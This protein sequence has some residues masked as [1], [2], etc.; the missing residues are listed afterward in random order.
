MSFPSTSTSVRNAKVE[1]QVFKH[2]HVHHRLKLKVFTRTTKRDDEQLRR[3]SLLFG[4][5]L[6]L[7]PTRPPK[8]VGILET[9]EN[10]KHFTSLLLEDESANER[11]MPLPFASKTRSGNGE[12]NDDSVAAALYWDSHHHPEILLNERMSIHNNSTDTDIDSDVDRNH[13]MNM[14]Q[15]VLNVCGDVLT[16]ASD[17]L[18]DMVDE[19]L[20]GSAIQRGCADLANAIGSLAHQLENQTEDERRDLA[21]ACLQDVSTALAVAEA[22]Q[23][24]HDLLLH[25][26][27]PDDDN[28]NVAAANATTTSMVQ[29]HREF[30]NQMQDESQ[31]VQVIAA[32]GSF[33]RD[34]E[35]TLR[36]VEQSEAQELADV[37]LTVAKIFVTSLQ[38]MH[39]QLRP[40]DL[41][42]AANSGGSGAGAAGGS[43]T[44][45]IE[46]LDDDDDDDER[47]KAATTRNQQPA[48]NNQQNGKHLQRRRQMNDRLRVLW[49]PLGPA[50]SKAL[51]WG[52]EAALAQP[53][54]LSIALAMI[55][56]P[57]AATTAI[58]GTPLVLADGFLQDMYAHFQDGPLVVGLE[59]GA[60][61]LF[62]TGR[63]ALVTGK[64]VG[65]HSLRVLQRQVDRNGGVGQIV[66]GVAGMAVD[67]I[68]HPVETIGWSVDQIKR[69][70]QHFTDQ[71][72]EETVQVLQQ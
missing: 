35:E 62:H 67:R 42:L 28:D 57:A 36:A 32:A 9:L 14:A 29:W 61:Q 48:E 45:R 17:V 64:V 19:D 3:S 11:K 56:W 12:N 54:L 50:V 4:I 66:A 52:K 1:F 34:V 60:A 43:S 41:L 46:L 63:L 59:R 68:T 21:Q 31:L 39:A 55:L 27:P 10:Q 6:R 13:H 58:I 30:A 18:D 69:L 40:R 5:I 33:L 8:P 47:E 2:F 44:V 25:Q 53:L 65:R 22:A 16:K 38:S 24:Q 20:L 23:A 49:P 15:H 71:E 7:P 72:R 37:A 51:D 70:L 26:M